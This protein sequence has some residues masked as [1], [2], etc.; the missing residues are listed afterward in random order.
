LSVLLFSLSMDVLHLVVDC[1]TS[2]Y[3]W[4]TLEQA[5]A[6]LYNSRIMHSIITASAKSI[7]EVVFIATGVLT[8]IT[9]AT[10]TYLTFMVF[11]GT[12]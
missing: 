9:I 4:R 10:N 6:S 1:Q 11:R 8:T 3:V 2:N 7:T 5:F 12:D